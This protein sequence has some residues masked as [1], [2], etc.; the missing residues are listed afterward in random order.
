MVSVGTGGTITG[1]GGY[2]KEK[3]PHIQVIAVEPPASPVLSGGAAGE[4]CIRDRL[5]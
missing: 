1:N 2:L 4:M 3:N 5:Y